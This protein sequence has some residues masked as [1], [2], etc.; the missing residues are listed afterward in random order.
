MV[1][2]HIEKSTTFL[3]IREMKIKATIEYYA[4]TRMTKIKINDSIKYW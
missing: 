4:L 3:V 1:D 2:K